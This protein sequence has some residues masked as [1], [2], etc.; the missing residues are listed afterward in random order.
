MVENYY[1]AGKSF[2]FKMEKLSRKQKKQSLWK[3]LLKENQILFL[4]SKS[5]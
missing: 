3:T 5:Q 2:K 4:Y 1:V